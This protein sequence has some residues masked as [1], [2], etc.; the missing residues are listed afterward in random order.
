V[1]SQVLKNMDWV[2]SMPEIRTTDT[3]VETS[4]LTSIGRRLRRFFFWY[5]RAV[6][7]R[8][9]EEEKAEWQQNSF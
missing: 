8:P 6:S 1:E 3:A 2:R 9:T 4:I 7:T 5:R